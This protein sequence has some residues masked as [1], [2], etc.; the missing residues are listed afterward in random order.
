[1]CLLPIHVPTIVRSIDSKKTVHKMFTVTVARKLSP[2]LAIFPVS[3]SAG[4]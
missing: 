1:M 2:R 4:L 3:H